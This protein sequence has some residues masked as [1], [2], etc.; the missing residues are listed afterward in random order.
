MSQGLLLF[1][2][3][4]THTTLISPDA[5][6]TAQI[7]VRRLSVAHVAVISDGLQMLALKMPRGVP[8]EPF[9]SPLFRF[10]AEVDDEAVA[11]EQLESFLR[12]QRVRDR[13]DDDLTLL[14]AALVR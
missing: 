7:A 14:L 2:H 13:T 6:G 12:S 11:A 3:H 10:V 4:P 9:F 5:L 8:H 1:T